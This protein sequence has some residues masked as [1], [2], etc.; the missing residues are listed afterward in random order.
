MDRK[1]VPSRGIPHGSS[2]GAWIRP[3]N[4]GS[5][6]LC[7]SQGLDL[8]RQ[9]DVRLLLARPLHNV[10]AHSSPLNDRSTAE[11]SGCPTTHWAA[12]L[13]SQ[14]HLLGSVHTTASPVSHL[15]LTTWVWGIPAPVS[16]PCTLASPHQGDCTDHSQCFMDGLLPRA[17]Q[18]EERSSLPYQSLCCNADAQA[19]QGGSPS[20][21]S[22]V[23][24]CSSQR[25]AR[26]CTSPNVSRGCC[27]L[28]QDLG[29]DIHH[30]RL[31]ILGVHHSQKGRPL[32]CGR[33]SPVRRCP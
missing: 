1:S 13:C 6:A 20:L 15:A 9:W 30:D 22:C 27:V 14:S 16:L 19:A 5:G 29:Q 2:T 7:L 17:F 8:S 3:H 24:N 28:P 12:M 33:G 4:S 10:C 32:A 21:A 25:I 18:S 31:E 23:Q 26:L 11:F